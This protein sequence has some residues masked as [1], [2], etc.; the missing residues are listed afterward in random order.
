MLPNLII[1]GAGKCGTTSLHEYLRVHPEVFMTEQKEIHYF[2]PDRPYSSW[3]RGRDWYESLF[4]KGAAKKVRGESSPG[5][6]YERFDE[7]AAERMSLLI[8][9]AKIIYLVRNPIERIKSHFA[10]EYY[11]GRLPWGTRLAD[12]LDGGP[13]GE[14][15]QGEMYDA[16]VRTSLYGRQF[17][18]YLNYFPVGNIHVDSLERLEASPQDFMADIFRFLQVD[19]DFVPPNLFQ[20][21]NVTKEKHR[22]F[23]NPTSVIRSLPHYE[24][25][26]NRM[27]KALKRLYRKVISRPVQIT[28]LT[29][30]P[31]RHLSALEDLF[32][33]DYEELVRLYGRP[34][35]EIKTK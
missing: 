32:N 7:V 16:I 12:I 28:E 6:S 34:F 25:V 1:I 3:S 23:V 10:E 26:S 5:Y 9:N 29:K 14:T 24:S 2:I 30:V 8:P 13:E 11:G 15:Q 22:R 20:A 27:P 21:W 33:K 19:P 35:E 17:G 18:R 4:D 31:A